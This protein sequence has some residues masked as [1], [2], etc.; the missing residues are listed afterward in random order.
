MPSF[1][2]LSTGAVMQ[3]PAARSRRYS[4]NIV[5][6]LDG[7]EQRYRDFGT[8]Y[9]R[10]SISLAG[11]DES[12]I[13]SIRVFFDELEGRVQE[14]SFT[15]PW[16]GVVYPKCRIESDSLKDVLTGVAGG[17]TQF[18]ICEEKG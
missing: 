4:T 13:Q 17:Q 2:V 15:D 6:F 1:P 7:T 10:W 14:F 5:E 8:A 18:S 3:Y 16:D 11:L 12:E 9:H